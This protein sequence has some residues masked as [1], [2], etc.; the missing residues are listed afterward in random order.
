MAAATLTGRDMSTE[1]FCLSGSLRS[2]NH[3]LV[4]WKTVEYNMEYRME[5]RYKHS[6]LNIVMP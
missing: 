2:A 6:H 4:Y 5:Y 3:L 1:G